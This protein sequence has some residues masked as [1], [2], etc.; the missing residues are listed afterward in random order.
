M[1]TLF[2]VTMVV[3]SCVLVTMEL[4]SAQPRLQRNRPAESFTTEDYYRV[5]KIDVHAHIRTEDPRFVEL[6]KRDRFRFV[7]IVTDSSG[8]EELRRR[9]FTAFAQLKAHP[10]RVIVASTFPMAGWDEPD[11][12]EK[13]IRFLDETFAKGAVAVK[14]WKNIGMVFRDK[15]GKLV[16][17]DDPKLDPIF[18]HLAQ[19]GIRLIGHLGEPR[20]CWLPV[21]RMV[22][23]RGY[24]ASHPE[25][26]MYLHPEMPSY[27]DQISARD[28]M[29]QKHPDLQFAGAH[30]G[31]LEWS[32]DQLAEF[33]D[34]FP[35]VIVE[36]AARVRDLQ[37]QSSLD[38]NK[39]RRFLIKYQ[40]RIAYGTD[41]AVPATTAPERAIENA[42][43]RWLAD[44]NYFATDK[45]TEV[46][47]LDE[48]VTGLQLPKQVVEK[49]YRLNAERFFGGT[50]QNAPRL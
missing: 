25:Y 21:E 8:Q 40:D 28:S 11:W 29:L 3:V 24:Y 37:Y 48:P 39:V 36:T 15:D 10:D 41:L 27:E 43:R 14:V 35:E 45:P 50:F 9:H 46:R 5:D 12:Q 30:L 17:I 31:S 2:R 33:L 1:K 13:T 23:H 6:A 7:N 20:E 4:V 42:R 44:W 47:Q 32:V 26:H 16:M 38:R 34:R 22:M 18:D 19:K 49:I